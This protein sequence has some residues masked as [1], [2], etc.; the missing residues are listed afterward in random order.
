M[1]LIDLNGLGHFKDRENAMI[2]EDFSASKAYAAGDYCYYNG[3]LYK[4]KTAHAAGAWTTS[5]VEAAKLAG[6]VSSLKESINKLNASALIV[7][8]A[9]GI[10]ANIKDGTNTAVNELSIEVKAIQSGSG[11]PSPTNI[12]PITGFS[13]AIITRVGKNLLPNNS[14]VFQTKG[15]YKVF[16]TGIRNGENLY[17]SFE[18]KDTT[19]N[20]NDILFGFIKTGYTSGNLQQSEFSWCIN[21]GNIVNHTNISNDATEKICSIVCYPAT[22]DALTRLFNR[23]NISVT[24]GNN[25][26]SYEP[27][28]EKTEYQIS[29]Q[30][31]AGV[32][33]GG[34]IDYNTRKLQV[35][36]AIIDLG[37]LSWNYIAPPS[38]GQISTFTAR[39][40]NKKPATAG[41]YADDLLC[42][43]FLPNPDPLGSRRIDNV[44]TGFT[45]DYI[46]INCSAYSDADAFKAGMTGVKLVYNITNPTEY[47]ITA[48]EIIINEGANNFW[49]TSGLLTM[50]YYADTKLYIDN[51]IA[52]IQATMLENIGG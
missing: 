16:D 47:T 52:E 10:V 35:T 34:I 29:F 9:S 50:Q 17:M 3:T 19:I 40:A 24:V 5:D 46:Y 18:D 13:N 51:K 22:D 30:T 7:E 6:D 8:E 4:F 32:I 37:D 31:G 20:I 38:A 26:E 45:N 36:S 27:Y 43:A 12:R 15:A 33:Y 42:S 44:I 1:P 23:F 49:S 28:S 25:A 21:N 39:I 11:N 14:S 2:A 48:D 41:H